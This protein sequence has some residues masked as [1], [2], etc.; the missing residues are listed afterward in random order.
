MLDLIKTTKER[1]EEYWEKHG[2]RLKQTGMTLETLFFKDA[3]EREVLE[4][5]VIKVNTLLKIVGV[6]TDK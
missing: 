1:K 3:Y 2:E 4:E 6:L 5:L